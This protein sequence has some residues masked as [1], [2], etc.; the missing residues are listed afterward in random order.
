MKGEYISEKEFAVL[1]YLWQQGRPMP[2]REIIAY[3]NEDQ[4]QAMLKQTLN[5]T[6]SRLLKRGMIQRISEER[7]YLYVPTVSREELERDRAEFILNTMFSGS[8]DLFIDALA[9]GEYL[10]AEKA[11]KIKE[12]FKRRRAARDQ[13]KKKEE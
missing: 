3:F 10:S 13:N 11:G 9:G 5:N 8:L 12:I 7:R 4:N 6:L 1:D 2:S